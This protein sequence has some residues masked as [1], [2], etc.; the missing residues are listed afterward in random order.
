MEPARSNQAKQVT[1]AEEKDPEE[2]L[3]TGLRKNQKT[4]SPK[5]FYDAEGSAL[6]ERITEQPEY[7]PTRTEIDI[8]RDNRA[9]IADACGVGCVMIEP[10]AGN[11]EKARLLF[12]AIRPTAYVPLDISA[13]FLRAAADDV[14]AQFPWLRVHPVCADFTRD[15]SFVDDLPAGRRIV[16]YPG[17]TIGNLEPAAATVFL[18]RVRGL[19]GADGGLLLGVDLHKDRDILNAAYN[20]AAGI[21][22]QFN[23]NLLS[24]L[25]RALDADFH[26]QHFEHNAFY[27]AD[28]QRIEM[29]LVSTKDHSV[30]CLDE[31][32][33][34]AEGETLHT[35]NS[36]KYSPESLAE[37]ATSAGFQVATSW[38]DDQ[39]L[40]SVHYLVCAP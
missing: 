15:W 39:R 10:G 20:D 38:F 32:I 19:V 12:D 23:V 2:E 27:N 26:P 17:S 16:F 7:Y 1:T 24:H 37:L 8:L 35:E 40:F 28:E 4:I 14:A 13:T 6:F 34:F 31:D 9:A 18:R 29:H 21:T 33:H 5:W 11:C 3:L 36:Y 22:A 25:N 30:R